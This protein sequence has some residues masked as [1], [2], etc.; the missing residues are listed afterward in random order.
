MTTTPR[1][2]RIVGG[3]RA[4]THL[5]TVILLEIGDIGRFA[6]VENYASYCRC[7]GSAHMT[8]ERKR[9][10]VIPKTAIRAGNALF[11]LTGVQTPQAR[12]STRRDGHRWTVTTRCSVRTPCS[13]QSRPE[14]K[15]S[16]FEK[17]CDQTIFCQF[18]K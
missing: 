10:K 1:S 14:E 15:T 4:N 9:A 7:V 6:D 12:H 17:T 11:F 18:H 3:G 16:N 5:A 8:N 13:A 2:M